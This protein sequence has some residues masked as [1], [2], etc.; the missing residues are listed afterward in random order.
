MDGIITLIVDDGFHMWFER[1]LEIRCFPYVPYF[2]DISVDRALSE[3][4][5]H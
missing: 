5:F 4:E 1:D 3:H 2:F